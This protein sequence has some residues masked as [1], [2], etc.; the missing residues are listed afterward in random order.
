M[1]SGSR[2]EASCHDMEKKK[3]CWVEEAGK[4]ARRGGGK[5]VK[6]KEEGRSA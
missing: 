3:G 5:D 2:K 4:A 1:V 6:A